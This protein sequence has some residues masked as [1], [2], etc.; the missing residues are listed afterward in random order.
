MMDGT[1]SVLNPAGRDP[2]QSFPDGAG[3]TGKEAHPPVNYHGYAACHSGS[4]VRDVKE[5]PPS[6][7]VVIVLLRKR[8]LKA[9]RKAILVLQSRKIL[10]LI[11]LKESG[12]HQVADFLNEAGRSILFREICCAAD[13]FL[14][15]TPEL[16][17]LYRSTGCLKGFFAPTP[18]PIGDE[19]W[20]FGV[21]LEERSGIFVGTREFGVPS[22]N[23]WR[24]VAVAA[25]L[26]NELRVPVTVVNTEGRHG[27]GILATFRKDSPGL[28]ILEGARPYRDYLQMVARHR[29]VLQ[30]DGSNVP[31]QVAG[32]ALLCGMP[33]IG[34]N[35]AVDRIAFGTVP[36]DVVGASR[37]LLTDDALWRE[38]VED[39]L[40]NARANLGFSAVKTLMD[41]HL[42]TLEDHG[43]S[44]DR[45]WMAPRIQSH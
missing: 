44:M 34:G 5:L 36:E 22:R 14:S 40:R 18:Y 3:S 26:G 9:A 17:P 16:V 11:S 23:H 35:G 42:A 19:T 41:H 4:H 27:R 2:A 7:K 31:G 21:P 13:G 37:A 25:A 43:I 33:C 45:E 39:A 32:D 20:N 6:T 28:R 15:S 38:S 10:S 8:N 30:L 1:L 24:A 29:L 12:A